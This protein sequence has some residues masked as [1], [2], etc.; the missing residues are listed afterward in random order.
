MAPTNSRPQRSASSRSSTSTMEKPP[1]YSLPSANGPSTTR[2]SSSFGRSTVA[3]DGAASPP[4]KTHA[5]ASRTRVCTASTRAMI[6]LSSSGPGCAPSVG[7]TTLSRYW[8]ISGPPV[9]SAG[10]SPALTLCTN[11]FRPDRQP[12]SVRYPGLRSVRRP[13]LVGYQLDQLVGQQRQVEQ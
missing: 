7:V 5:P 1:R 9:L 2:T 11:D 12:A 3:D 10:P 8:V 13:Q 4:E 6:A